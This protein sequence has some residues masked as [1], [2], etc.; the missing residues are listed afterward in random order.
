MIKDNLPSRS[1][2]E[3]TRILP[4]LI[5][6]VHIILVSIDFANCG[7]IHPVGEEEYRVL[8][9]LAAGNL[10][11][12]KRERLNVKKAAVVKFWRSKGRFTTD[13]SGKVLLLDNKRASI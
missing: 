13:E 11:T 9:S 1:K 10:A 2:M 12:L 7:F 8:L 6:F 4:S 3:K 5:F